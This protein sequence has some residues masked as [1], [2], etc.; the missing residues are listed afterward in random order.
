[1]TSK[2]SDMYAIALIWHHTLFTAFLLVV[3]PRPRQTP[4]EYDGGYYLLLSL[5]FYLLKMK[6][7]IKTNRALPSNFNG[8]VRA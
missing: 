7:K 6:A 4:A 3:N 2:K 8:S 1:M 5:S